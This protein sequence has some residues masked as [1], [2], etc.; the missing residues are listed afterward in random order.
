MG[1]PLEKMGPP[2]SGLMELHPALQLCAQQR[3]GTSP[4]WRVIQEWRSAILPLT[5]L[6]SAPRLYGIQAWMSSTLVQAALA[7]CFGGRGML[8]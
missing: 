6:F 4:R 8:S 5:S 1:P 2:A 7:C 3:V